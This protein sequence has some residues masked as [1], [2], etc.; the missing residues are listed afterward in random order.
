MEKSDISNYKLFCAHG[1]DPFAVL[2][3][4]LGSGIFSNPENKI[5]RHKDQGTSSTDER[6]RWRK[7]ISVSFM[8]YHYRDLYLW[9]G[10]RVY[11]SK[12]LYDPLDE[13]L[14]FLVSPVDLT[15]LSSQINGLGY[16]FKSIREAWNFDMIYLSIASCPDPRSKCSCNNVMFIGMNWL[17][18]EW[19]DAC[20]CFV[21]CPVIPVFL[22]LG[23]C[24]RS[25]AIGC[26]FPH[27][28]AITQE[29]WY[30]GTWHT[31]H[32]SFCMRGECSLKYDTSPCCKATKNWPIL[33][34]QDYI[35]H[36]V[37]HSRQM[38]RY[39]AWCLSLIDAESQEPQ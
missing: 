13:K 27:R 23:V 2:H 32:D 28:H 20:S 30:L 6:V 25:D 10:Q 11:S 35:H 21:V 7:A 12:S 5:N 16:G 34:A 38:M 29:T 14:V 9:H 36:D 15:V 39:H 22:A 19:V 1:T 17:V 33:K 4:I 24:L 18:N 3:N 26:R 8:G 37:D 31:V